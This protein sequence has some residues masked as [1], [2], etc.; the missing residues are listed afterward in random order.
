MIRAITQGRRFFI[1]LKWKVFLSTSLVLSVVF[2]L[3]AYV[4]YFYLKQEFEKGRNEA[5]KNH[6]RLFKGLTEQDFLRI[7]QLA[8]T[9]VYVE[10]MEEAIANRDRNAVKEAIN[11]FWDRFI[12]TD[13]STIAVYDHKNKYMYGVGT[14][15]VPASLIDSVNATESPKEIISCAEI[16]QLYKAIPVLVNDDIGVRNG[17]VIVFG[18]PLGRV[19]ISFENITGTDAAVAVMLE[20]QNLSPQ[21]SYIREWNV[22]IQEISSGRFSAD[23]NTSI[24]RYVASEYNMMTLRKDKITMDISNIVEGKNKN[25]EKLFYEFRLIPLPFSSTLAKQ[26]SGYYI[27]LSDVTNDY[28]KL[29]GALRESAFFSLIGL[30]L[31]EILVLFILWRPMTRLRSTSEYLPL[32]AQSSFDNARLGLAKLNRDVRYQDESDILNDTA[33]ALSH[34]LEGLQMQLHNRAEQLQERGDE[35]EGERDF[36]TGLLNTA[37]ALILTQDVDGNIL[38]INRHGEWITGYTS[39]EVEGMRFSELLPYNDVIPDLSRQLEDLVIGKRSEHQHESD[40]ITKDGESIHMSWFHSSL[41]D[42]GTQKHKILTIGLDISERKQAEDNL[43]WL[44]SHDALT[45][46]YNRR[47]FSDD[48]ERIIE[49]NQRYHRLSALLYF[50]LDHFKE[51]NDICGHHTGDG[52]L[53]QV[54]ELLKRTARESDVVARLGGDEFG[55]IVQEVEIKTLTH[56]AARF[57]EELSSIKYNDNKREASVTAS[58]GI[59]LVPD[60]GKSVEEIIANADIAMYQ[61]KESGR[62]CWHLFDEKEHDKNRVHERGYWNE[63]L[64]FALNEDL[65]SVYYQPV[66]NS[67]TG[68]VEFYE[69]LLRIFDEKGSPYPAEKIIS[70]AERSGL[71]QE[72]DERIIEK[73]VAQ[74]AALE[75][76]GVN[77]RLSVNLSGLSLNNRMLLSHIQ[78]AMMQFDVNPASLIFE[79]SEAAAVAD[80]GAASEIMHGI[81][82]LG[83]QFALDDFGVGFSSLYY[84]KQLPIDYIKIDGSFIRKIE[85]NHEDQ[86]L[87]KALVEVAKAFGQYTIAE[88]VETKESLDMLSGMGVNYVQGY[89]ISYPQSADVVWDNSFS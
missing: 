1:S 69:A 16:C 8:G 68:E 59:S 76:R 40:L 57:V 58:I 75:I 15:D 46:L 38:M 34:Q 24:L 55:V 71:I 66:V 80:I 47:R 87:V 2:F 83:C 36:V 18:A 28:R 23:E 52:L 77:V 32:L 10:G 56:T 43:G 45:G 60:H 21:N 33:L 37:H 27:T 82:N 63:R 78:K 9:L 14:V 74:Q 70:A 22:N 6:E 67:V 30:L 54:A 53:K 20:Q 13:I 3:L 81:K 72:L 73:V 88:Y 4:H 39:D 11:V 84:L 42:K 61:A 25:G 50:D 51:V 44:A 89:Y 41:S 64:K 49:T 31:S 62:N 12:V 48:L 85:D 29:K 7:Q 17:G 19:I 86:Q 5:Y 79:I 26:T 65:I 35:L